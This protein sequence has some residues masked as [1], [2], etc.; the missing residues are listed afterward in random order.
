MDPA[1]AN[2]LVSAGG[3]LGSAVV[4]G[5]FGQ[6]SAR[7]SMKWQE[8]MSNTAYQRAARDLEKAGLNRVLALGSPASTPSGATASLPDA[9]LGSSFQAG[10][11]AKVQ[12][13]LQD[14][15]RKLV[16]QQEATEKQKQVTEQQQQALLGVQASAIAQKVDSEIALNAANAQAAITNSK[17]GSGVAEISSAIAKVVKEITNP[18]AGKSGGVIPTI[19][20]KLPEVILGKE[21]AKAAGTFG[22][23]LYNFLHGSIEQQSKA[24]RR[25]WFLE[26]QDKSRI[27]KHGK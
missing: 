2:G 20:E 9:K 3:D 1:T 13:N 23:G 6:H 26:D 15:S 17:R 5:L 4:S 21:G 18:P 11:S 7:E 16:Q 22:S 8:H 27:K 14:E 25:R 19:V 10:S 24:R 12:R